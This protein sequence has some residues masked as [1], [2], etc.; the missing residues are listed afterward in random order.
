MIRTI[1]IKAVQNKYKCFTKPLVLGQIWKDIVN[2]IILF[3]LHYYNIR[4]IWHQFC[5]LR[6]TTHW[7]DLEIFFALSGSAANKWTLDSIWWI[8]QVWNFKIY[9]CSWIK[10]VNYKLVVVFLQHAQR[11]FVLSSVSASTKPVTGTSPMWFHSGR[12][13]SVSAQTFTL[14]YVN[15][16]L[17]LLLVQ[18]GAALFSLAGW[19]FEE[20]EVDFWDAEWKSFMRSWNLK[21]TWRKHQNVL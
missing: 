9:R 10:P 20:Q 1:R 19:S 5:I 4:E 7:L 15:K 3:F 16:R 21:R 11:N 13:G 2:V 14:R 18:S 8:L 17:F 6:A 12:H